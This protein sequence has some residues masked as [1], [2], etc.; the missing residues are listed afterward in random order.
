MPDEPI[1]RL[2][3]NNTPAIRGTR[4]TVF[5]IMDHYFGGATPEWITDFF[6]VKPEETDAAIAYINSHMAEL[7]PMYR[8]MLERD[9]RGNSPE[10][11][12]KFARAHEKLMRLKAE[13]ERR[14]AEA[15]NARIAS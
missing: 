6:Q 7:M 5:S 10:V 2:N 14:K 3:R 4:L 1:I 8:K 11:E 9:Q 15:A 13:F 12:A